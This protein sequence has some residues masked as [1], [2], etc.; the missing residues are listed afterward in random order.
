MKITCR[1]KLAIDH[2]E[3]IDEKW[4]G[5]CKD[6]PSMYGYCK[7]ESDLCDC[8]TCNNDICTK[9]WDQPY[10]GELTELEKRY[11]EM[12]KENDKL[13]EE[14]KRYLDFIHTLHN[15]CRNLGERT[16]IFWW[17][18]PG[19]GIDLIGR[20]HNDIQ[21]LV[22][23]VED[24]DRKLILARNDRDNMEL[25]RN[26]WRAALIG[27]VIGLVIGTIVRIFIGG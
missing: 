24:A 5:G 11:F 15:S 18:I 26:R 19:W 7:Q 8:K 25:S 23:S 10:E 4:N 14:H 22:S 16:R 20:A 12:K 21:S 2:P 27:T 6:C 17:S 3:F 1:E 9:C 13:E